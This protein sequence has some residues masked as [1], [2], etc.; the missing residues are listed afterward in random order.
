MPSVYALGDPR[1]NQIHYIGIAKDAHNRYAQHLLFL[2]GNEEKASWLL[3]L[4]ANDILP[5]LSILE[6]DV[7]DDLILEKEREWILHYLALGMPLTNKVKTLPAKPPKQPNK[8]SKPH[9]SSGTKYGVY[10][11]GKEAAEILSKNSNHPVSPDYVRLLSNQGK[12]YSRAKDGR[13]KEYL[14]SDIEAYR[15]YGKG[16]NKAE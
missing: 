9:K 1:T 10:I 16:K 4:R 5:T 8:S 2:S 15:V 11:S 7:P 13:T 6:K 12:I 3:N 14:K